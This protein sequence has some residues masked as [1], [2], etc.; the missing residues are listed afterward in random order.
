MRRFAW[1]VAAALS[2]VLVK[3]QLLS[4]QGRAASLAIS[5]GLSLPVGNLNDFVGSGFNLSGAVAINPASTPMMG[6]RFEGTYNK[7]S[8]D[9]GFADFREI[10]GTANVVLGGRGTLIASPYLIAGA[11]FYNGKSDA[12]G[13]ASATDFGINGGIGARFPLSGF[14]TFAE[15]RFH[16]VFSA[17]ESNQWVPLTFGIIF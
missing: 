2:V 3:P 13:A 12:E 9:Q 7:F 5:G 10:S 6:W 17:N 15:I 16:Q 4:A 8:A 11:G 1:F 14:S